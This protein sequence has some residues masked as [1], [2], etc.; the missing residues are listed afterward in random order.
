MLVLRVSTSRR[1]TSESPMK[2]PLLRAKPTGCRILLNT[3][4]SSMDSQEGFDSQRSSGWHQATS[5]RFQ[6]AWSAKPQTR[7]AACDLA[8]K[9]RAHKPSGGFPAPARHDMSKPGK[10]LGVLPPSPVPYIM[11][12][13]PSINKQCLFFGDVGFGMIVECAAVD[14]FVG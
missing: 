1:Q 14:H 10:Y 3:E 4:T 2:I 6:L 12:R 13:P 7:R 9:Q 11:E 8:T 5:W